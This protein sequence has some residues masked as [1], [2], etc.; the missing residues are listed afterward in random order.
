M[1]QTHRVYLANT[2]I[3][4]LGNYEGK[5]HLFR[6]AGEDDL[7]MTELAMNMAIRRHLNWPLRDEVGNP[8]Y[9]K[10]G[11]PAVKNRLGVDHFTPHDLRRTATTLMAQ[12]K[13]IKEHRERVTKPERK[14]KLLDDIPIKGILL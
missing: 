4:L 7:P 11:K 9:N 2:A 1:P 12:A 6:T 10:D 8:L 13:I 14:R 3:A 5:G